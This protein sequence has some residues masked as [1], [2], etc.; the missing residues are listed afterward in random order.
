MN[1]VAQMLLELE[2]DYIQE[3][4]SYIVMLD[5]KLDA[6]EYEYKNNIEAPTIRFV[7]SECSL[8]APKEVI[9]WLRNVNSE[10][11]A[12]EVNEEDKNKKVKINYMQAWNHVHMMWTMNY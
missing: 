6:A 12:M 3:S 1:N 4:M 8:F 7:C 11:A 2:S 10:L 9:V 5:K